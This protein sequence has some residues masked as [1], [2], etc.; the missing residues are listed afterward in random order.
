MESRILKGIQGWLEKIVFS[1]NKKD[2]NHARYKCV[3]LCILPVLCMYSVFSV[4]LSRAMLISIQDEESSFPVLSHWLMNTDV[5]SNTVVFL[6]LLLRKEMK[7]G[8]PGSSLVFWRVFWSPSWHFN[9]RSMQ[10]DTSHFPHFRSK[11]RS[12]K[13]SWNAGRNFKIPF[14][15]PTAFSVKA[16]TTS[17]K[18]K[19]KSAAG[20]GLGKTV[21]IQFYTKEACRLTLS[22]DQKLHFTFFFSSTKV[23]GHFLPLSDIRLYLDL[24]LQEHTM[25]P[26]KRNPVHSIAMYWPNFQSLDS[27]WNLIIFEKS[28]SK[29]CIS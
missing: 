2:N 3:M 22:L 4:V 9:V 12:A 26:E 11:R 6:Y 29:S 24:K 21:L 10:M 13:V 28:Q 20:R 17:E 5:H 14:P 19:E 18:K 7:K 25:P 27:H 23:A 8:A 1:L 15:Y 16:V